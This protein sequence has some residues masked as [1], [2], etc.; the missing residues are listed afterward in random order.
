MAA[1]VT[2]VANFTLCNVTS[3]W[4][5]VSAFYFSRADL[6]ETET[7]I[8]VISSSATFMDTPYGMAVRS[9]P[10]NDSAALWCKGWF[11]KQAETF[12]LWA[13][14]RLAF[15]TA[16]PNERMGAMERRLAPE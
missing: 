15:L 10:H 1:N 3:K 2:N 13:W 12:L 6:T 16:A 7:F 9:R 5:Q 8:Q 11:M 14:A 4:N